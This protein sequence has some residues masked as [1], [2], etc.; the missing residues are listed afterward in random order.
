[1][2]ENQDF[3]P[4]AALFDKMDALLARLS[5]RQTRRR[6]SRRDPRVQRLERIDPLQPFVG[7]EPADRTGQTPDGTKADQPARCPPRVP[8]D[9]VRQSV[10]V[11]VDERGE[12][13][14][15]EVGQPI[16]EAR[17]SGGRVGPEDIGD[18][19]DPLCPIGRD[20]QFSAVGESRDVGRVDR[21]QVQSSQGIGLLDADRGHRVEGEPG[22]REDRRA[23]VEAVY[24]SVAGGHRLGADEPARFRAGLHD[25][26]L[27]SGTAQVQ[28]CGES[29]Q[30]RADN[31]HAGGGPGHASKAGHLRG[32]VGDPMGQCRELGPGRR[33]RRQG[34]DSAQRRSQSGLDA[35][36]DSALCAGNSQDLPCIGE[37]AA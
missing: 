3:R 23:C 19:G 31:H 15:V 11:A 8:A 1:M 2:A 33:R 25:G 18:R 28:T 27:V 16:G 10:V 35:G 32:P 36:L 30:S 24:R 13:S 22:H 34:V 5:N 20:G 12:L 4:S 26:H 7:D 17:D 29:G 9:E 14:L 21:A 6:P 37:L